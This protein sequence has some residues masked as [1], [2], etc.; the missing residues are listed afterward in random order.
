[1]NYP[2]NNTQLLQTIRGVA[3]Q[4]QPFSA[5][6]GFLTQLGYTQSTVRAQLQAAGYSQSQATQIMGSKG[7]LLERL[8]NAIGSSA[9]PGPGLIGGTALGGA[10]SGAAG[11]DAAGGAA[12]GSGATSAITGKALQ[13]LGGAGV[14]AA[15]WQWLRTGSNWIRILEYVG[16]AVLIFFALRSVVAT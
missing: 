3:Q 8:L 9:I 10:E 5:A 11:A 16:G 14:A 12:A 2:L 15:I 6:M 13:A 1:M 4:G 7:S